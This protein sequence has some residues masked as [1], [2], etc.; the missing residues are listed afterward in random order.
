[1][2]WCEDTNG[3]GYEIVSPKL[4]SLATATDNTGGVYFGARI[5][6]LPAKGANII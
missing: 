2:W 1:M 4:R 5:L 3:D 6:T